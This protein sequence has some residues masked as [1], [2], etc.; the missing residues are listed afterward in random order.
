MKH[1]TF[2]GLVALG[3]ACVMFL[4][5]G[6]WYLR[7][8][9]SG[10]WFS[11]SGDP[12]T[13]LPALGMVFL[14][15]AIAS[16]LKGSTKLSAPPVSRDAILLITSLAVL[17]TL[18]TGW[19]LTE[20]L[21]TPAAIWWNNYGFPL[22]WRVDVMRG[23]PPWCNLPSSTT[24]FNLLSFVIDWGF[25]LAI[26]L[27]ALLAYK[28]LGQRLILVSSP[29]RRFIAQHQ[30]PS[31]R[32]LA[33]ALIAIASLAVVETTLLWAAAIP[34]EPCNSNCQSQTAR[35]SMVQFWA[36]SP[37]NATVKIMNSGTTSA[38][39]SSYSVTD[40]ANNQ[41]VSS[42]WSGPTINPGVAVAFPVTIDGLGFNFGW[43]GMYTLKI[44]DSRGNQ[45]TFST[46]ELGIN[47]LYVSLNTTTTAILNI[48]NTGPPSITFNAYSV[49]DPSGHWSNNTNWS[50]PTVTPGTAQPANIVIDGQ[51]FSFQ[52]GTTYTIHLFDTTGTEWT[53]YI[54]P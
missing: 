23:C 42:S 1:S 24:T 6:W 17:V 13:V 29:I 10:A 41:Y 47:I 26:G 40:N 20:E 19:L 3:L 2:T 18:S 46:I 45:Y 7:S 8:Q 48:T 38:T 44:V 36:N 15:V 43:G 22:A 37:T 9:L 31:S 14:A 21:V 28:P 25:F 32:T 34:S 35:L 53:T 16:L 50:G 12:S 39:L 51:T 27:T 33:V 54:T 11:A 30:H 4:G 49:Q 52:T 5:A